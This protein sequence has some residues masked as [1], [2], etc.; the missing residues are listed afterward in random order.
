MTS[1][2]ATFPHD[3]RS[4][5]RAR[6]FVRETLRTSPTDVVEV[7]ELMVSELATNCFLHAGTGFDLS[8][9][10]DGD[11]VRV[12][13]TDSGTGQPHVLSPAPTEPSG[14]GLRIVENLSDTWGVRSHATGKTVWFTVPRA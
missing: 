14:R 11:T 10:V 1:E 9:D 4:V 8:V 13:V 2:V 5:P 6:H 7:T 12:E 3:P